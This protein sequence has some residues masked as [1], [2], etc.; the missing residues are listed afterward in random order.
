MN[1]QS[2]VAALLRDC[3]RALG[4]LPA[5]EPGTGEAEQREYRRCQ[6]ELSPGEA[7]ALRRH[8]ALPYFSSPGR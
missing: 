1:K 2:A 7:A 6:G 4:A 3:E 5:A 8:S